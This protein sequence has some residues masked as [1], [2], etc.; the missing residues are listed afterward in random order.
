MVIS[1]PPPPADFP[2]D[3]GRYEV[4]SSRADHRPK[5]IFIGC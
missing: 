4:I 5:F 2:N 1:S 3:C